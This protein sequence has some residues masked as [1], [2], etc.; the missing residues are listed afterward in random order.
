MTRA[1]PLMMVVILV[2]ACAPV[3]D[4]SMSADPTDP[5]VPSATTSSTVPAS[6]APSRPVSPSAA[7]S[8]SPQGDAVGIH[9]EVNGRPANQITAWQDGFAAFG[10]DLIWTS[11]DGVTWE[12]AET[13]G[14]DG[15]V[16][17]VVERG[18]GGLLAFGYLELRES[19]A[20]RTWG[21]EDGVTWQLVDALPGEFVFLDV[22]YGDRGYVL[23]GRA[24]LDT[25]GPNPEQL[26]YSPDA[27]SW[28]LVRDTRTDKVLNAVGAGPEGFVAAGQ[29][30][31]Q[32]GE[33]YGLVVASSDGR[34]WIEASADDPALAVRGMWTIAPDGGDWFTVPLTV[35]DELPILWSANGVD[36]E[37][38]STMQIEPVDVGVLGTMYSDGSR[39]FMAVADGGGRV[40]TS[41]DLLVS[42]DGVSWSTTGIPHPAD[43]AVNG[44]VILFLVDGTVY[45]SPA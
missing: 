34:N 32:S 17:H 40:V 28:E 20:F 25:G 31:W 6:L 43:Y 2:A 41:A 30:G 9:L 35:Y 5:P 1:V 21:S 16:V 23:A 13:S 8:D 4:A 12:V 29:Q 3:G 27:L 24:L 7:A 10:K 18:D 22:A 26:W 37:V 11:A 14:I 15:V 33:P 42:N 19:D 44:G 36:W 45:R 39:L 38:R